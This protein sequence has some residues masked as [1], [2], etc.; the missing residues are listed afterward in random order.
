MKRVRVTREE[1]ARLINK[2]IGPIDS[3]SDGRR[4]GLADFE[5]YGR[6][7]RWYIKRRASSEKV[8]L[9]LKGL[10]KQYFLTD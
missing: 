7:S 5:V 3:P 9:A 8:R 6:G 1:L 10:Q 2:M 4:F